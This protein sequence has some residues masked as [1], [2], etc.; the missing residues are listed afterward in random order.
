[1]IGGHYDATS[2]LPQLDEHVTKHLMDTSRKY[3]TPKNI[4]ENI[5][6]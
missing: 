5:I 6:Y 3:C 4:L 1:M 2:A